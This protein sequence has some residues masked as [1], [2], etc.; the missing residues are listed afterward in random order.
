MEKKKSAV[1]KN[2]VQEG[3]NKYKSNVYSCYV[4]V[5]ARS[6]NANIEIDS[7]GNNNRTSDSHNGLT[8]LT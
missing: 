2:G 3:I 6:D 5:L 8:V 1:K 4:Y 7:N